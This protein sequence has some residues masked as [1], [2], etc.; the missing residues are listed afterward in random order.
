MMLI[1]I[2][3]YFSL[4]IS[5]FFSPDRNGS[6]TLF[7][8]STPGDEPI[9][10]I[11]SIPAKAKIDFM[12]WKLELQA[13][14]TF[15]LDLSY[16]E[17]RPNT[18]G[19]MDTSVMKYEGSFT[20]GTGEHRVYRL[21]ARGINGELKLARINEN[22]FHILT[23]DEQLMVGNGGWSYLL[24]KVEP[25]PL[26]AGLHSFEIPSGDTARQLV[27][28]GRTP[29]REFAADHGV[30]A[31]PACFKVKWR[32]ILNRDPKTLEPTTY[33]TRRIVYDLADN[34][35][36]WAIRKTDSKAFIIQLNPDQPERSMSLLMLDD[37][38]L[39]FLDNKGHP[40]TGN[41]DFS[42]ALNR[43]E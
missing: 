35:G 5:V 38:I 20:V 25:V 9:R 1:K 34:V 24:N 30:E 17:S 28:D 4:I 22:I 3:I 12:R 14:G 6:P 40:Y 18:L 7:A 15:T 11:L 31:N 16:G 37:N 32:L 26:S 29:C 19:F 27:F 42:F 2:A 13:S 33:S 41:A 43:I 23:E 21:K 36:K 39:Y 10:S 8:G